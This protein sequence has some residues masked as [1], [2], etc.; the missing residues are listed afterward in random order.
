[1]S[2]KEIA[3][4]GDEDFCLGFRLAGVQEIHGQENFKE[5]IQDL[6]ERED[7]GIVVAEKDDIENLP[8][9]IREDVRSSVDPVVVSLSEEG[10]SSDLQEQIRKVIGADI[11]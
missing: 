4:I 6:I 8:G 11:S 9:R 1:M 3:V 7:I 10:E 2:E 5:E